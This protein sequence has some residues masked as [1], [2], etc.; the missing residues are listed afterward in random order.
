MFAN[1]AIFY[2]NLTKFQQ[3]CAHLAKIAT[4]CQLSKK[5]LNN[6]AKEILQLDFKK[7]AVNTRIYL[8]SSVPVQPKTSEILSKF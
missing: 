4:F 2:A 7:N 5:Q 1:F 8:Q 3:T 6:L